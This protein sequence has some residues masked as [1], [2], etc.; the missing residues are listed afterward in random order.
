MCGIFGLVS[1]TGAATPEHARL[2]RRGT[3]LLSHRG[4]DGEGLVVERQVCFGHR[5]LSIVDLAGGAQPMWSTD[6]R[7]LLSYNGEVYNF[8]DLERDLV[9]EGRTFATRCDSEAVLNA[10]LA[11]GADGVSRLRGMFAFAAVDFERNECLLARDRLGKKPLYYTVSNDALV[12]SSELEPLYQTLGPFEMDTRALDQ[13]LSWQYIPSPLTIYRGVRSLPPGHVATV[14]LSTAEVRE[15]RYWSLK[16]REDH[17]LNVDE[18]GERLDAKIR[19]AVRV[20]FMSDVP[21]GAFLSGGIDSS[22]IVGYMA[23]LMDQPVSTFT[24]G[25]READFS[26]TEYAAQVARL[27]HTAHHMEVV[28]A[29]SM[30]LLPVLVRHYGQPFADSSAIPTYYVSRMAREHVKMVLSGD[31]G[32]EN[33]AGYNSYEYVESELRRSGA[34]PVRRRA[35]EWFRSLAGMFYGRAAERV[36]RCE[37]MIDRAYALHCGTARHFAP[38]ERRNLLRPEFG[39][40]VCDFDRKRRS[41]LDLK[42]APIVS[43]LQHLDL[44]AYLPYD[45]LTK[46]DVA[47][48]ANSL[49]VRVPLLDHEL[50]EMAATIPAEHKLRQ[51]AEQRFEKKYLLKQLARK[52]YSADLIDRPKMGFGVPIGDWMAGKLRPQVE[53]RLLHSPWLPHLFDMRAVEALWRRHLSQRDATPKVW[54]LLFLAEWMGQHPDAVPT[55]AR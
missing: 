43:R 42:D 30:A 47:A 24:I 50:V 13:Y 49:E 21:F 28:E 39:D 14:D 11:W 55:S 6:R 44:M 9:K 46:V 2:V 32:D 31:G 29:D 4:P 51:V 1:L 7:G 5:R 33:F 35:R 48:M 22:L 23:E 10:Y 19:D 36:E 53:E 26:E 34:S 37:S 20:R 45:I 54:N 38:E 12:W 8:E 41:Y 40:V 25:F 3:D 18:W 17:S 27:N 16:F 52:R 15:R